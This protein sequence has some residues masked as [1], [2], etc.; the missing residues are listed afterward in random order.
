MTY[1][2][3]DPIHT[4]IP[5]HRAEALDSLRNLFVF[6]GGHYHPTF[7]RP[8]TGVLPGLLT[9]RRVTFDLEYDIQNH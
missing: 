6:T 3:Q 5:A 7:T 2:V 1:H 8:H 9:S 4:T